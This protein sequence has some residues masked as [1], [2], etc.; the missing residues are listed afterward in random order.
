MS[1]TLTLDAL[2]K[3]FDGAAHPAVDAVSFT[4]AAGE[5]LAILGP[6]GSGKSTVLRSIAGL[7]VPSS[8]RILVD[9]TEV[10]GLAPERRGMAMV[11][12]RPLLFPHLSVLDNVAFAGTVAGQPRREARADAAQ[13]LDLV[14]LGGFGSRAVTALSGGQEQRVALARALAARPRVL[15]LDEPFSALDPALRTDMHEL[16]A[17]IRAQLNPTVV[18]VTHDRDEAAVVADTVALLTA[19]RLLQHDSVPRLYSRP[20]SLAVSRLMG[21]RNEVE[22]TVSEGVHYSA[23]GAIAAPE[24][25]QWP[26]GVGVLVVRQEALRLGEPLPGEAGVRGV[27]AASALRGPRAHVV[28]DVNGAALECETAAISA[29]EVGT[30]VTVSIPLAGCAVLAA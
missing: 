25:E 28:V 26:D 13:F 4:V 30:E 5:C 19:G 22:G 7:D 27:V 9:G 18:M 21:G 10:A 17:Q 6:S 15:L 23:L 11:F 29:P 24:G 2:T 1:A 3:T 8:G 20:A 12:Q 16:L 14:Q